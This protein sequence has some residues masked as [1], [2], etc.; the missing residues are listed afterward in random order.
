[1]G[2][3]IVC[4]DKQTATFDCEARTIEGAVSGSSEVLRHQLRR[5]GIRFRYRPD[6]EWYRPWE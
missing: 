1:V 4:G 6:V 5:H 3:V 2:L